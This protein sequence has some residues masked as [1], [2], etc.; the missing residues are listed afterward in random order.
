MFEHSHN[1]S[2]GLSICK[3][4]GCL[5]FR[6]PTM[7]THVGGL[8]TSALPYFKV[9]W[10]NLPVY[11]LFLVCHCR[12]LSVGRV[13][14]WWSRLAGRT[15]TSDHMVVGS[16]LGRAS[17]GFATRKS[18][19]CYKKRSQTVKGNIV[20]EPA[21]L[22]TKSSKTCDMCLKRVSVRRI[23]SFHHTDSF[24]NDHWA[25]FRAIT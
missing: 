16:N 5:V 20:S 24:T 4:P 9:N 3:S 15:Q 7:A 25:F 11:D 17:M 21:C 19:V 23:Q 22:W 6:V 1:N 18:Y 13:R 14:Q 2:C 12:S 10:E 8:H